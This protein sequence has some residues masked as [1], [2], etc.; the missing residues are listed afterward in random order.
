MWNGNTDAE[1]GE[2]E[3]WYE[4]DPENLS[5]QDPVEAAMDRDLERWR[6]EREQETRSPSPVV[7]APVSHTDVSRPSRQFKYGECPQCRRALRPTVPKSGAFWGKPF[8]RCSNFWNYNQQN[9]RLCWY[10]CLFKGSVSD[11]PR[12]VLSERDRIQANVSWQLKHGAP[13]KRAEVA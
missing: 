2:E 3:L 6:Q 11:L 9:K 13:A 5:E 10:G 8:L 1:Q 4:E 7:V 12:S